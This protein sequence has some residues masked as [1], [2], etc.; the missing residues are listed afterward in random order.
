MLDRTPTPRSLRKDWLRTSLDSHPL[1]ASL[2]SFNDDNDQSHHPILSLCLTAFNCLVICHVIHS[3]IKLFFTLV[4]SGS[5]PDDSSQ[6]QNDLQGGEMGRVLLWSG[7]AG[8]GSED[9]L[10]SMTGSRSIDPLRGF[11]SSRE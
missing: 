2:V 10:D 7:V 1:L 6:V 11:W 9:Q 5:S 4:K 8:R 3:S